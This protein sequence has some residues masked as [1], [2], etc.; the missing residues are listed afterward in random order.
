MVKAS[1]GA[2]PMEEMEAPADAGREP[3]Q[4][5]DTPLFGVSVE[6]QQS[7]VLAYRWIANPQE[8]TAQRTLDESGLVALSPCVGSDSNDL[9][10]RCMRGP[11]VRRC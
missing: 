1:D 2:D 7:R 3:A 4:F 11:H 10:N 5:R 9:A 6:Q 8:G